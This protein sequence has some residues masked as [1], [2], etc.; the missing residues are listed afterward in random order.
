MAYRNKV[1]EAK[2]KAKRR[3]RRKM[4]E[5]RRMEPDACMGCGLPLWAGQTFRHSWCY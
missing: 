4:E 3:A 2:L 1:R 5:A